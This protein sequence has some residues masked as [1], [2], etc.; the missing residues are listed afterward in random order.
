VNGF[1][2]VEALPPGNMMERAAR[3]SLTFQAQKIKP[4]VSTKT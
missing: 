1:L 4:N 2:Q 3:L